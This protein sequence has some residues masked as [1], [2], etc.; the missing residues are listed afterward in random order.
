MWYRLDIELTPLTPVHI[1]HLRY[2]FINK[3]KLYIPYYI[4]HSAINK[5][6]YLKYKQKENKKLFTATTFMF[7]EGENF[8]SQIDIK[9]KY[10]FSTTSTAIDNKTRTARENTLHNIEF[11]NPYSVFGNKISQIKAKG[12]LFVKGEFYNVL[13]DILSNNQIFIGGELKYGYGKT[14]VD[15]K[16]NTQID[17][18]VIEV[19]NG[20]LL[21][22]MVRIDKR[23]SN[24][25]NG[26]KEIV[27]LRKTRNFERHGS[28]TWYEG[29][30]FSPFSVASE[31]ITI[32]V[33]TKR[34]IGV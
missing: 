30:F 13:V 26:D 8:L 28:W 31:N 21:K 24:L 34:L 15:I 20:E 12:S 9:R 22:E 3:T 16:S 18:P 27:F 17:K 23:S 29:L 7:Y 5:L 10:L 2:G 1:G 11:I 14:K 32:D 6:I 33:A 25:I 19:S 4:L